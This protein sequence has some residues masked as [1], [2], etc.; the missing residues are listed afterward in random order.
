MHLTDPSGSLA[1]PLLLGGLCIALG[2][3][4][5]L[6]KMKPNSLYGFR[7][8]KTLNDEAVWYKVNEF[9]GK[10]FVASGVVIIVLAFVALW[11]SNLLSM[12]P[13]AFQSLQTG[14]VI[15]PIAAAVIASGVVCHRA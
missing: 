2:I 12:G 4:P 15:V 5:A 13:V 11:L 9:T 6:G 8:A 3:P 10:A 14:V 1:T 7:L